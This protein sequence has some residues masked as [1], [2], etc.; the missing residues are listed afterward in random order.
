LGDN[1]TAVGRKALFAN[2][3]GSNNTAIGY[4]AN[5]AG[6]NL[7]NATA[8]GNGATVTASNTI[9][10]GNSSV[11]NVKTSGTITAD[12]VTYPNSHGTSGQVLTTLGS[13]TLSWTSVS[14]GGGS[15]T[16]TIGESYG[17]G[18]VFY[19]TS[20]GKHGLISETQLISPNANSSSN[21]DIYYYSQAQDMISDSSNH[22]TDGKLYT[23]WRLP[24][25]SEFA[26]LHAKRSYFNS[27]Y[28]GRLNYYVWTSTPAAPPNETT[29]M[30]YYYQGLPSESGFNAGTCG[31]IAIRSF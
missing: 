7:T 15:T 30:V 11:T 8:I 12:A 2:T 4:Y 20:D 9:Q 22:S 16:H 21:S 24:T 17:G 28:S 10:L 25:K 19:V 6:N 13:G 26:K 29:K 23:D 18:I 5:V 14:S 31:V 3:T 1:N 27:N